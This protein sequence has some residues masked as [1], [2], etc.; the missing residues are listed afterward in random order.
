MKTPA[1]LVLL[2]GLFPAVLAAQTTAPAQPPREWILGL[3][4][5]ATKYYGD[6]TD[7][8]FSSGASVTLSRFFRTW[9]KDGALYGRAYIGGYD[10][11]W[12][13][14]GNAAVAFDTNRYPA[15]EKFRCFVAP[16][17]AQALYR[18]LVGPKAELFL[19]A[20]LEF[21][22]FTP[23]DPN[24]TSLPKPQEQYGKWTVALPLSVDFEYLLSDHLALN[25]HGMLHLGFTDYLDGY[26]MGDA[27]DAYLTA[28]LGFSYSFPPPDGDDD[29]DGLSNRSE[30]DT[31]H[32]NPDARDTDGDGL[33]DR[34]EVLAGTSP[35]I[36][37]TDKDGL[38]DGEEVH[39]LQSNPLARD[40]DGDGLTDMEEHRLGTL[41]TRADS[42]GD[43]LNDKEEL[44]R[45]TNPLNRDTDGDGL[46]DGLENV[47]SPLLRDTDNDGLS[48]AEE[49]A[50]FLRPYEEDFDRDGLFD[51]REIDLG[52]DPKKADSDNDGATDYM[53]VYGIM[54]DPRHP[55][56][57][58]DGI[59][60][61]SD[62][63]P[64]D[65]TP[66]NPA[67]NVS[68]TFYDLFIREQNVNETSR[69]FLQL[70]HLIRS[71]PRELL[72]AVDIAVSGINTEEARER[73]TNLENLLNR[74]TAQWDK[75]PLSVYFEVKPRGGADAK[76]TYVWKVA[77][78]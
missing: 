17:G 46:P 41:P 67:R 71:A 64:L 44:A 75:A 48:D 21:A 35:L 14:N 57:D 62:P 52:T 2:L 12:R 29:Y 47:S 40:T 58:H 70:L 53:E 61:G 25:F 37:D 3:T 1:R 16:I 9:G 55:D 60:D 65:G 69:S 28:G 49:F 38:L 33:D 73:K 74:M 39:T 31:Y 26:S 22:Y 50:H 23:Q 13:L 54:T 76:L 18:R 10:L 63:S 68:W 8:R 42:D 20:G 32:T 24:G 19:G 5:D 72:F 59:A 36:Q 4:L 77:P 34:E 15:G 6:F 78:R 27:A 66:L 30:G 56:T 43:G 51:K 11:Q 45:S 7:N